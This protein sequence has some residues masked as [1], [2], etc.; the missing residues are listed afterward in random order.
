MLCLVPGEVRAEWTL[1]K[2]IVNGGD[3]RNA[4]NKDPGKVVT[5]ERLEIHPDGREYR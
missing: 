4:G 5:A 1:Y 3:N 2:R